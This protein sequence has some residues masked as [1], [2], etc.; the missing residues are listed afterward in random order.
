MAQAQLR[1]NDTKHLV[2]E[3]DAQGRG[4]VRVVVDAQ[5]ER[6]AF[7][8]L[9]PALAASVGLPVRA[10]DRPPR[11]LALVGEPLQIHAAEQDDARRQMICGGHS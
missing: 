3:A 6:E 8:Q 1:L 5:V 4:E 9:L 7:H 2:A 11:V 10:P